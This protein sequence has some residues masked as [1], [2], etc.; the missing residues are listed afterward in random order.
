MLVQTKGRVLLEQHGSFMQ[1]VVK[2]LLIRLKAFNARKGKSVVLQFCN[3]ALQLRTRLHVFIVCLLI[4]SGFGHTR[5]HTTLQKCRNVTKNHR[6]FICMGRRTRHYAFGHVPHGLCLYKFHV[7]EPPYFRVSYAVVEMKIN[8]L[9]ATYFVS[10]NTCVAAVDLLCCLDRKRC[11]CRHLS[12]LHKAKARRSFMYF[13]ELSSWRISLYHN[14]I[15]RPHLLISTML[16]FKHTTIERICKHFY[17]LPDRRIYTVD[18]LGN[19]HHHV[20]R[21]TS[22]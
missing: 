9:I 3:F 8:T 16:S 19:S 4:F 1:S 20:C 12:R 2:R 21:R 10:T 17:V 6:V 13:W 22:L 18:A 11:C 7:Y 14:V 15:S 5:R